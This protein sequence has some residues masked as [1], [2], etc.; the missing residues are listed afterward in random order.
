ME[1]KS[2][3]AAG[4]AVVMAGNPFMA[5]LYCTIISTITAQKKIVYFTVANFESQKTSHIKRLCSYYNSGV[6]LEHS[7]K[8]IIIIINLNSHKLSVAIPQKCNYYSSESTG[9]VWLWNLQRSAN[10]PYKRKTCDDGN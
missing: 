5:P 7:R 6:I 3:T 1:T 2:K 10:F 9:R 4:R 8:I